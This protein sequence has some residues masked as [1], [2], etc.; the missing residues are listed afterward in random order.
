MVHVGDR[1]RWVGHDGYYWLRDREYEILEVNRHLA[2]MSSERPNEPAEIP[3]DNVTGEPRAADW[4]RVPNVVDVPVQRFV[5]VYRDHNGVLR[6]HAGQESSGGR[7]SVFN[8]YET[9]V[10]R[11]TITSEDNP[12]LEYYI[13][14]VR[15]VAS[16][17]NGVVTPLLEP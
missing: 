16:I 3:L 9:V 6:Q 1:F 14:P 2:L 13:V 7:W 4:V 5:A 17:L 15:A 11:V 10:R 12:T 8:D